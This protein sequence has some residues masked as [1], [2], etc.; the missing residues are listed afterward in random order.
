MPTEDKGVHRRIAS[1]RDFLRALALSGGAAILAACGTT[2]T[3]AATMAPA[4]TTAPGAT[5]APAP[6]NAPAEA[7]APATVEASTG[8]VTIQWMNP[9]STATTQEVIPLMVGEFQK[10]YPNITV[11]YE[12]P[13]TSD[14]YN[15][16]LLS[17]IAGGNPPDIA[18]LYGP[19]AEFAARG[20][21]VAIDDL[22]A[23]AEVAKADAF[24]AS[25]LKSCQWQGKTYGLPSSAGAGAIYLGLPKFQE[26][27]ITISRDTFP[28]TWDE[29]KAL[30]KEFVVLDNGDIQQAGYVPFADGV[31]LY[32][33]WSGLNGGKLYDAAANRYVLD[34]DANVQ[35][36]DYWL[37]WLDDQYGGD[38]EKVRTAGNWSGTYPDS[39]FNQGRSAM[40][41]EGSW[42][43]TDAEIPFD[44]EVARFPVGPGG[45]KSVT[46]F[47][48]NWWV[49]PQGTK[50]SAEAFLFIEFIATQG[51][52]IW[53]EYIMDTPAWK[54][55]PPTVLT[56]KL[57]NATSAERATDVNKFF[58]DY[59]NDAAEM[60]TSP[61]ESFANDTL[62]S[63]VDEVLNKKKTPKEAL[64]DAQQICQAKLEETLKAV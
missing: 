54:N 39:A 55:F 33:A 63:A 15:E 41:A 51:W 4:P 31:W 19:P 25:P 10:K 61:I 64:A 43:S 59:L 26:K 27:N 18:T 14:G 23:S 45:S 60:W 6:T 12:N 2:G 62:T 8:T 36:L 47:W 3:P 21:L 50:Y 40:T 28:K 17:R 44:W 57:V 30:S 37:N 56:T 53:Y 5:Q 9:Y 35:W 13:G 49:I 46:A 20:S 16:A 11:E 1:R 42:S 38:I 7:T 34:S 29:L 22:M 58:A 32:P 48:P 24:F 52:Q